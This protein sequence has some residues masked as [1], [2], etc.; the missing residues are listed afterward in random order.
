[1]VRGSEPV[2]SKEPEQ[3]DSFEI[4]EEESPKSGKLTKKLFGWLD[5]LKLKPPKD[6]NA[7]EDTKA[8]SKPQSKQETQPVVKGTSPLAGSTSGGVGPQSVSAG[9]DSQTA[10]SGSKSPQS[11]SEYEEEDTEE[12]TSDYRNLSKAERKRLRRQQND[13]GAA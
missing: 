6:A 9:M 3:V 5:G 13:R 1:M 7:V 11:R 10:P 8:Q 2:K 4:L 12:D